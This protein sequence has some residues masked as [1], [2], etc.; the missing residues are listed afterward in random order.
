MKDNMT[1]AYEAFD[2]ETGEITE[3][4][5]LMSGR[6]VSTPNL[7]VMG[8]TVQNIWD[9]MTD[10]EAF[11]FNVAEASAVNGIEADNNGETVIYDLQG[12]KLNNAEAPGI[13]IINGEKKVVR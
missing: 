13:Y 11:I 8:L 6:A 4:E 2:M 5:E 7:E 3:V 12:R 10:G 1:F 9:Y